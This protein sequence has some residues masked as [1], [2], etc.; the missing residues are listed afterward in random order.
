MAS[1]CPLWVACAPRHVTTTP[2]T[3]AAPR[4]IILR[5]LAIGCFRAGRDQHEVC[6]DEPLL[7][8]DR[9]GVV[10]LDVR[11]WAYTQ[12]GPCGV[13]SPELASSLFG[14]AERA[15]PIAAVDRAYGD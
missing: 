1:S 12:Q 9:S 14:L 2:S 10:R 11:S 7:E 6:R 4:A 8:V 15:Q 3:A 13:L 5:V